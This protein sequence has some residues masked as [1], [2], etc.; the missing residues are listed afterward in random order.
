MT[1]IEF[2]GLPFPVKGLIVIKPWKVTSPMAVDAYNVCDLRSQAIPLTVKPT[3][4]MSLTSAPVA[5]SSW[6]SS[7]FCVHGPNGK[8]LLHA[9]VVPKSTVL[10]AE[11]G[12]PPTT[13]IVAG[14]AA[15]II[16]RLSDHFILSVRLGL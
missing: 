2:T 6:T 11:A 14:S 16:R 3:G 15:I 9:P 12:C 13:N 10:A 5:A 1:T 8:A 4:P 7:L